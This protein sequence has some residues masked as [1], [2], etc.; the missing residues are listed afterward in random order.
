MNNTQHTGP[1]ASDEAKKALAAA[2]RDAKTTNKIIEKAETEVFAPFRG[3]VEANHIADRVR[4][5]VLGEI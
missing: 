4:K 5:A 1:G 2:R 3:Y